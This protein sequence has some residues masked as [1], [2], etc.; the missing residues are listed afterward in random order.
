MK[1]I[2]FPKIEATP[3]IAQLAELAAEIWREYY[4]SIITDEQ[5]NYMLERYQSPSAIAEQIEQQGYEYYGIALNGVSIGYLAVREEEEGKLFL[6]KF[7]IQLQHRGN[8]YASLAM[9]FLVR[10]CQARGL[11]AIWLTA[12]RHNAQAIAVYTKKGF[13]TIHTQVVDIGD[14]FVMDDFVMEKAVPAVGEIR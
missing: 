11:S 2:H 12:N 1:D 5:I 14:G 6:S 4:K 13:R 10:L 3:D 7:Y 8:G 9:A